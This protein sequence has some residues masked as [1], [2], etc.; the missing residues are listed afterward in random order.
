MR[1]A[2][3]GGGPGGLYFARLVQKNLPH[4]SVTVFEQ[5]AADATFG[6]GV[7]LGGKARERI[8]HVD[9]DVHARITASMVFSNTQRIHINGTDTILEYAQTGGA[10]GRLDLLQIL[11]AACVETGV[12]TNH[13]MKIDDIESVA[14]YDLIVGADGVNST[15]RRW[16]DDAFGTSIYS[17]T[18]HF[19]WYGVARAMTPASLVFRATPQGHF[20]GHYYPYSISM[21]TFVAECDAKTWHGAGLAVMSDDERRALI[22]KIFAPELEGDN[23]VDNR[24]IWRNFPV[25]T[26]ARWWTGK[27]VLMGDALM[28]AHFSIGSGTRLA[29]DDALALFEALQQTQSVADAL[30]RYVEIRRPMRER[31]GLAARKSF[32]WYENLARVMNQEPVDFVY[33]FL[34]RTGRVDAKRLAEYCPGFYASYAKAR[35]GQASRFEPRL[36]Q[37]P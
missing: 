4:H 26:N 19:A 34:T 18:N 23:L 13:N 16:G 37:M 24:S 3:I 20:V 12:H 22:E 32:T 1:I 9:P 33:D 2:V 10:I 28:S 27:L 11:Q 7:G 15:V 35:P 30:R 6:F 29:M 31:F 21:S 36:E 8:E 14:D 5:N 25:I 17:L